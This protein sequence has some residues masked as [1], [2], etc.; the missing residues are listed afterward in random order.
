MWNY[1]SKMRTKTMHVF[2]GPPKYRRRVGNAYKVPPPKKG[3]F[4]PHFLLVGD[5]QN[6]WMANAALETE[7]PPG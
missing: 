4:Q 1:D 2:D 5:G 3:K 7:Y 6:L